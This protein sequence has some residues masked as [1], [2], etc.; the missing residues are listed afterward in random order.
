M[1]ELKP[2][3]SYFGGK[4][5]T[6]KHYPGP[7]RDLIIEPFAGSA[8]YSVRHPHKAVILNDLSLIHISEPTRPAA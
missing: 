5:R 2:F 6:A 4:W 1:T 8:G 3:F 7:S